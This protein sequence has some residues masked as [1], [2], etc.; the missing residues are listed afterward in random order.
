MSE[1]ELNSYRFLSGE[2]PTDELLHA[3]MTDAR[4]EAVKKAVEAQQK[5]D[6]DYERQFEQALQIW[7]ER[8]RSASNGQY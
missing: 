2:E 7:D 1:Q 5:F 6:A 4:N 8:V 3:I